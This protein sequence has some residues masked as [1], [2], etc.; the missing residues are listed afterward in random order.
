MCSVA[1]P[2]LDFFW[3]EHARAGA[4]VVGL[5]CRSQVQ[6]SCPVYSLALLLWAAQT[7]VLACGRSRGPEWGLLR[8]ASR[9]GL[10]RACVL[11]RV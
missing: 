1:S 10:C 5:C 11:A 6:G 9:F 7:A 2:T 3:R 8:N 4:S